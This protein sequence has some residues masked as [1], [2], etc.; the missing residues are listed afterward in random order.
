M[1]V[2]QKFFSRLKKI[3]FR[4]IEFSIV[5]EFTTILSIV[6]CIY[7]FQVFSNFNF[8]SINSFVLILFLFFSI[9]IFLLKKHRLWLLLLTSVSLILTKVWFG[10]VLQKGI[11]FIFWGNFMLFLCHL[12]TKKNNK[13][14]ELKSPFW[15]ILLL[16]SSLVF[17]YFFSAILRFQNSQW[18]KGTALMRV[19]MDPFFFKNPL[20]INT[21][22]QLNFLI[23]FVSILILFLEIIS[24]LLFLRRFRGKAFLLL[25]GSL[26]TMHLSLLL[27]TTVQ[28]YQIISLFI[29]Y[30][31][32]KYKQKQYS[33]HQNLPPEYGRGYK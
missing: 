5:E 25:L 22:K 32:F 12:F 27:F 29:L 10:Y 18:L 31:F 30:S 4:K 20:S 3:Y 26:A 13:P 8:K 9:M 33:N 15:P 7:F 1:I 11:I 16:Q 24:P 19:L 28:T 17:T 14:Q 23:Q 2:I 21:L 6:N